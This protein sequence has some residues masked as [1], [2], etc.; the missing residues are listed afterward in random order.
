[1]TNVYGAPRERGRVDISEDLE[2]KYWSEKFGVDEIDLK[3][4]VERVGPL[5]SDIEAFFDS[6]LN[7]RAITGKDDSSNPRH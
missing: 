5:V 4:A 1:M 3:H 2:L 7:I 6:T